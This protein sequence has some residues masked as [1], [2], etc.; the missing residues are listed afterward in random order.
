MKFVAFMEQRAP[1]N[2]LL[3]ESLVNFSSFEK[4]GRWLDDGFCKVRHH[5][6]DDGRL[7]PPP[8]RFGVE[9]LDNN[10]YRHQVG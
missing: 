4:S 8:L 3:T 5:N 2:D 6:W 7:P 10:K 1:T 9:I